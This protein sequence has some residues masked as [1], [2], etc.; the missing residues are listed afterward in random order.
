MVLTDTLV[1]KPGI[2]EKTNRLSDES[3]LLGDTAGKTS[4][5]ICVSAKI[6]LPAIHP[7]NRWQAICFLILTLYIPFGILIAMDN[8]EILLDCALSLFSARGYDAVGIQEIVDSAGV[9]KPTLYHYFSH[10]RGLL[11]TL[12]ASQFEGFLDAVRTAAYYQRDLPFSLEK[13]TRTYFEAAQENPRFFRLQLI[14]QYAPKESE[15]NQAVSPYRLEQQQIL[16]S[17]FIQAVQDHG[18]MR[19]RH[20]MYAATFLGMI[21]T[22]IGEYLNGV[23]SLADPLTH[24]AVHQFSHG[25]YS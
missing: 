16:Q 1:E 24:L 14:L 7:K 6:A 20:V 9:T 3:A 21:H 25:I 2:K 18:N 4:D 19:G 8:R 11:D 15:P 10:K 17:M 23:T 22:Y 12:L 13:I 5:T